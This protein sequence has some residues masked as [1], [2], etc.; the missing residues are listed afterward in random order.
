MGSMKLGTVVSGGQATSQRQRIN[1]RHLALLPLLMFYAALLVYPMSLVASRAF[2]RAD[3]GAFSLDNFTRLVTEPVFRNVIVDTLRVAT[4]TT[5]CC[6]VLGYVVAYVICHLGPMGRF[7]EAL[8]IIPLMTSVLVRAF[9]W[10]ALLEDRGIVNTTL[11]T[12]GITDAPIALVYNETGVLIGMIHVMLPFTI[13]PMIAVFRSIDPRFA[14]ASE[15]LGANPWSTFWRVYLPLSMPGVAAGGALC[16]VLSLG[17]FT[18]PAMLGGGQTMLLA[19]LIDVQIQRLLQ[20]NQASA[21]ALSLIVLAL[22]VWLLVSA[23][24]RVRRLT[25][26]DPAL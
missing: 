16:F 4:I 21:L 13:I 20:L 17:F 14:Q 5:V 6:V 15:S 1:R 2:T 3:T 26:T 18:T 8:V 11:M 9:V 12:L 19:Q 23:L 22:I 7:L 24:R 10:I 25:G